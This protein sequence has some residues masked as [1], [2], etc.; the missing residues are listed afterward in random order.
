MLKIL[1]DIYYGLELFFP[2]Q[3]YLQIILKVHKKIGFK[4]PV[5]IFIIV[6]NGFRKVKLDF[7]I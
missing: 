7:K 3:T 1:T 4:I 5:F 6:L 2:Q